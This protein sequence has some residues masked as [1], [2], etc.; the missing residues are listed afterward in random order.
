MSARPTTP[1]ALHTWIKENLDLTISRVSILPDHAAPFDYLIHAF[2]EGEL[3]P[4]KP[5]APGGTGLRPAFRSPQ[6]PHI[7]DSLIWA[8]RGGGKTLLGAIATTLD[9][10]FK[11]SIQVRILAGSLEQAQRMHEHLRTFFERDNLKESVKGK[12]TDRRIA[13]ENGSAVEL[14]AQSQASVRGQRPHKLRC[15]EVE[16]FDP[17]VWEAAQLTT[18][19]S[20]LNG[21]TIYGAIECFSTMHQTHGLM[22]KLIADLSRRRLFKWGVVDNLERCGDE[23]A[24]NSCSLQPECAGA[25]K[26][27]NRTGHIPIHD[28]I[29]M[30][31]RVSLPVW[32]SEMLCLR[33]VRTDAVFPEFDREIHLTADEPRPGIRLGGMDFGMRSP[34]VFLWAILEDSGRLVI[35]DEH[36][37]SNQTLDHHIRRITASPH[38][39]PQ[40]VGADPSG[41]NRNEHSGTTSIALLQQSGLTVKSRRMS[42]ADGLSL[43]RAR[44]RPADNS[45]PRLVIHK[46]CTHLIASLEQYHYDPDRPMINDPVKDGPDHA[47]DALRYLITNL[48]EPYRLTIGSYTECA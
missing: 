47:V 19:S 26:D 5:E 10:L 30:K 2:F 8:N 6:P 32:N 33:P 18:R 42:T 44:L 39:L 15:D 11:P 27:K 14:L 28:A 3:S 25:A 34:T 38:Q 31:S 17:E 36:H 45:P 29:Q 1:D 12:I 48:D 40:W 21:F 46:R 7:P 13:L 43:I 9:L 4:E 16:L 37:Q 24:C 23:R 41:N 22:S 35:V 20:T